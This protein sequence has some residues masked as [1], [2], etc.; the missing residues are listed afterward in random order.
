MSLVYAGAANK[1][2]QQP[3]ERL[4]V[5]EWGV[6][7]IATP[8]KCPASLFLQ[9]IPKPFA[10]HPR[11]KF[12]L[13]TTVEGVQEDGDEVTFTANYVGMPVK[14]SVHIQRVIP[15][16][17]EDPIET[18]QKFVNLTQD[19]HKYI[20]DYLENPKGT[21]TVYDLSQA[22]LLLLEKKLRGEES[23]LNQGLTVQDTYYLQAGFANVQPI[24]IVDQ[25]PSGF[26][27]L[28]KGHNY[29]YLPGE[30]VRE[31]GVYHVTDQ[32]RASG[33]LG[34]DSDIY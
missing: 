1:L 14:E 11:Y 2:N 16:E 13:L 4:V 5:D 26:P 12:C 15:A 32:Y 34:W 20:R 3:G 7:R 24:G 10:A 28:P 25:A 22:G 23:F 9:S 30:Q 6:W 21:V 19:E 33:P 31:G 17:T 18:H 29:L 27:Q 8:Y